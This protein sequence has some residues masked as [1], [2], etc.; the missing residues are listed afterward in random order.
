MSVGFVIF[1]NDSFLAINKPAGL[2]V[3]KGGHDKGMLNRLVR[4]HD[5]HLVFCHRLD[6]ETSGV[7]MFAK[8]AKAYR[9]LSIQF[10]D[11]RVNKT[12]HAVVKG[13]ANFEEDTPID[14]PIRKTASS[15]AVIDYN[16]G[17][18][19]FTLVKTLE[20]FR[21]ATL[22]QCMILTG[23]FHQIRIHLASNNL[24]IIQDSLYG[25]EELFLSEIKR[26]FNLSKGKAE[27]PI[28][29]RIAL[30]AFSFG[31]FDENGKECWIEAPYPKDF[32]VLLKVLRK[33]DT[34]N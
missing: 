8:H 27:S 34:I 4:A 19:A 24:P 5:P 23:R 12:Y 16:I 25:G 32:A 13:N 28:I 21:H 31:Y 14:L 15:K 18:E 2:V 6:K 10:E 33:Y 7:L 30:H 20:N 1:E 22:L 29:N 26:K 9:H 3:N 17:K 11:R